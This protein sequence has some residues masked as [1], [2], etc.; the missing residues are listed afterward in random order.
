MQYLNKNKVYIL[1]WPFT[2]LSVALTPVKFKQVVVLLTVLFFHSVTTHAAGVTVGGTVKFI[3]DTNGLLASDLGLTTVAVGQSY[4]YSYDFVTPTVQYSYDLPT[5]LQFT[6]HVV[7]DPAA[8]ATVSI[9]GASGGGTSVL[10]NTTQIFDVGITN[11]YIGGSFAGQDIYSVTS[12]L[13]Q[14][15]GYRLFISFA[16]L[17]FDGAELNNN[18]FFVESSLANYEFTGFEITRI[19]DGDFARTVLLTANDTV[20]PIP[21]A[22]WLFTSAMLGLYGVR[23]RRRAGKQKAMLFN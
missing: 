19:N 4:S 22:A 11:D 6:N 8:S 23:S 20:V 5:D 10:A 16:L 13:F 3:T 12:A 14:G 17:D 7:F 15:V 1:C 2:F 9:N 21:S 18:N